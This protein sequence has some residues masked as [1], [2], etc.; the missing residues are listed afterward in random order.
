MEE[1]KMDD[2][3]ELYPELTLETDD[4]I[5][6]IAVKKDYS[7]IEDLDKRKEE[8]INDLNNFIKEFSETPESDDFMR[9][10]DY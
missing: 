3:D 7:R 9:Y 8:F 4:M 10:Y 2:F 5:M 6:T 1:D